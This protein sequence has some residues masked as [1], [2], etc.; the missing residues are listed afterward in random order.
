MK[1]E[2]GEVEIRTKNILRQTGS[3]VNPVFLRNL[4]KK[5]FDVDPVMISF[6]PEF[7]NS[8]GKKIEVREGKIKTIRNS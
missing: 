2:Q 6:D 8:R 1:Q 5:S 7:F 4:F 3:V